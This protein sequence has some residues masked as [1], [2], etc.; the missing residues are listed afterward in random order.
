MYILA[1]A[2]IF[3]LIS[4]LSPP[5]HFSSSVFFLCLLFLCF[6]F[7][8]VCYPVQMLFV[9]CKGTWPWTSVH[10]PFDCP[11]YLGQFLSLSL[12]LWKLSVHPPTP[13][14]RAVSPTA[15]NIAVFRAVMK[16]VLRAAPDNKREMS[17]FIFIFLNFSFC[18]L[19]LRPAI[20]PRYLP[21]HLTRLSRSVVHVHCPAS[22][23]PL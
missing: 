14:R 6:C 11:S 3:L 16:R 12:Y 20:P 10:L 23:L 2:S 8:N 1:R 21:S 18:R 22:C 15:I 5:G 7:I 4:V 13:V 9:H 19:P 17:A